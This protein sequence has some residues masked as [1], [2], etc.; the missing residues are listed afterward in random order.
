MFA[1]RLMHRIVRFIAFF[2][3]PL[4]LVAGAPASA[5]IFSDGYVFLK[6]VK[7]KDGFKVTE[8]L[9][10]PGSTVVNARDITSGETALHLVVERRDPTWI[11]FLT[12]R[13]ANPNIRDKNGV[14]PLMMAVRLGF[15][16]GVEQLLAAG[17][18]V[19]VANDTGE[20]P[21]ISA[22]HRRDTGLMRLLLEKGADP[23]RR[24]NSGRSALDYAA[25]GGGGLTDT[26][27]R[28]AKSAQE[29][30]AGDKIYGPNF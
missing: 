29:R 9:D 20:T 12:A 25:L 1:P 19:D 27:E 16:E 4:A 8:M 17:A 3:V 14:T 5:Q 15:N 28:Y 13:G 11:R 18:S 10:K 22:L 7:D 30:A 24:D 21:L 23:D 2:A 6:A 26:I